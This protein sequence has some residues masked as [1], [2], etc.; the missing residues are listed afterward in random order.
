[1]TQYSIYNQTLH[2]LNPE[3]EAWSAAAFDAVEKHASVQ[4]LHM[5]YIHS[6]SAA[7]KKTLICDSSLNLPETFFEDALAELSK[8][9]N[10]SESD[11]LP[12]T[13]P[14]VFHINTSD[15]QCLHLT[16]SS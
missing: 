6:L 10:E 13:I 5:S 3:A 9:L 8:Q 1:M 4:A 11:T 14:H 16:S 7:E 12:G 2:H 15:S